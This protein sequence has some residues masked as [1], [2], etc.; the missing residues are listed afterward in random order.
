MLAGAVWYVIARDTPEEDRWVRASE[1]D[2]I[3]PLA[4]AMRRIAPRQSV[5]GPMANSPRRGKNLRAAR[6][7]G[8]DRE[9]FSPL[10]MSW[11]FFSWFYI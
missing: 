3:R 9:L 4:A 6:G 5:A 2:R 11:V 1:L 7:P 8:P 10:A